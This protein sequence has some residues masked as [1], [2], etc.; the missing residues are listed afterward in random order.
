MEGCSLHGPHI[1]GTYFPVSLSPQEIANSVQYGTRMRM[2]YSEPP[3]LLPLGGEWEGLSNGP[4]VLP[5]RIGFRIQRDSIPFAVEHDGAKPCGPIGVRILNNAARHSARL[6]SRHP[7]SGRSHSGRASR[8]RPRS[9]AALSTR[10][11][12]LPS[13][14]ID[15][16]EREVADVFFVDDRRQES[17]DKSWPHGRDRPPGYR[18]KQQV[19]LTV[20]IRS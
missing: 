6:G 19:D 17:L 4:D 13:I 2:E 18:T 15:H 20:E 10:Q 16:T 1:S 9:L 14:V 11:P 7:E 5:S 12:P 8:R 3:T